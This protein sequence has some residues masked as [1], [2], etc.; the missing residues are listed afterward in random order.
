MIVKYLINEDFDIDEVTDIFNSF[1]WK[2][3]K[4]Q[5][6]SA[7]K[8][9][10]YI[11]AYE[12][13]KL[14]GFGRAISDYCCYTSIHDVLV[15]KEFQNKGIGT[16]IMNMLVEKFSNT[17]IYLTHAPDKEEF[18][19]KFNFDKIDNAMRLKCK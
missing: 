5:L 18:Y 2:R 4:E 10:Y 8:N 7:F 3:K 1:N 11:L 9:S 19:K 6:Y 12:G 15:L 17:N 14:I 13:D 16:N